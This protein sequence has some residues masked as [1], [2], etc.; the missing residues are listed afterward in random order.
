ME[1]SR[2]LLTIYVNRD[3]HRLPEKEFEILVSNTVRRLHRRFGSKACT[4]LVV[5]G[6]A[7][8]AEAN[9][10]GLTKSTQLKLYR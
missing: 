4:V 10:V 3:I 7:T 2:P 8:I 9:Y 1:V 5:E 6:A